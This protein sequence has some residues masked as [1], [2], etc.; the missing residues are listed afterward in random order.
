MKFKIRYADQI[1]GFFIVLSIIS[2]VFVVVM[3]GQSQRWFAKDVSFATIL[4]SAGGLSK[5]MS[6]LY[7]GFTIGNIKT[8][9]LTDNDDVEVIFMIHEGYQDR[10]K[11]GSMVQMLISPVGLGNQFLF[12]SGRG[13]MLPEGSFIPVVGSA[14]ARELI[15]QGLAVE[16]HQDDSISVLVSR[17]N[18]IL[19]DVEEALGHGSESTEIGKI[20]NSLQ[21]TLAGA[22]SLPGT[23]DHTV[24]DLSMTV[25]KLLAELDPILAN[26]T[27]L[28]NELN[29]P[30]GL[31]YTVLDTDKDV[32]QDLVKSLDSLSSILASLDQ[33]AAFLPGQ[34]PHLAGI[35]L[36]LRV[37]MKAAEDVLIALTNNPLL[38]GGIPKKLES[39]GGGTSPRNIRF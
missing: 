30:D 9:Y 38:R 27:D 2:L 18:S 3:L 14:Q 1:V 8:F 29:N 12:H 34:L 13:E 32:Y 11:Q 19:G 4:P 10:V 15:R 23:I 36:E 21:K 35:I 22:E 31:I 24:N 20:I 26:I 5:N 25:K 39:Q 28:T 7:R 33:V 16:P 6:I 17:V 37:T